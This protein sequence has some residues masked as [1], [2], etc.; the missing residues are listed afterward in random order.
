M[1]RVERK[2]LTSNPKDPHKVNKAQKVKLNLEE[3]QTKEEEEGI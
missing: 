1:E 3:H 2:I